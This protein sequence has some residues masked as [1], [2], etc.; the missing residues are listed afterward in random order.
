M[1]DGLVRIWLEITKKGD[2]RRKHAAF[3]VEHELC[4]V[5]R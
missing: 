1:C 4:F 3:I 5:K 2:R